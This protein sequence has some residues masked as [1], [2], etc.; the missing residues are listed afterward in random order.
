MHQTWRWF[1]PDDPVT[2]NHIQQAG[3]TGIV[4]AL[5]EY[6]P[7]EAWPAQHVHARKSL[8]EAAGLTWDVCESIW[9]PDAI[10][11][12]GSAAQAE[13]T[14]WTQTMHNLAGAGVK[15]ICYNFMPLLD[16]TRTDLS[17]DLA[18]QGKVRRFASIWLIL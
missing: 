6:A 15:T 16:W 17:F 3:A 9:M 11:L 4:S 8:I 13:I 18:G 5:H 7:G 10:K 2:L 12:K 14:A 1:G